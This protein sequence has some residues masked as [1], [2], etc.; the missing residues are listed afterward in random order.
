M[1]DLKQALHLLRVAEEDMT[2]LRA[3]EDPSIFVDRM[4]AQSC[5]RWPKNA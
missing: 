5:S 2:K 4:F 3:R 1:S